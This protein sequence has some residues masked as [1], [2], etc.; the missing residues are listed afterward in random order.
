VAGFFIRTNDDIMIFHSAMKTA[1]VIALLVPALPG[2]GRQSD[3]EDAPENPAVTR[4][5][6]PRDPEGREDPSEKLREA[7]LAADAITEEGARRKALADIAWQAVGLDPEL[8]REA[9]QKLPTDADERIPLIRHFAMR[10]AGEDPEAALAWAGQLGSEHETAVARARIAL[11]IADSDPRRAA[12]LVAESGDS[13][14]ELDVAV[15]QVLQQW[16]ARSPQEAAE[17]AVLFPDDQI[18][19]AGIRTV[20]SRWL[21]TDP[22]AAVA[23]MAAMDHDGARAEVV[24]I[25]ARV[26][27]RQP[28]DIREVW[29]QS[30]DGETRRAI[31]REMGVPR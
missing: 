31:E 27:A 2:C 17:W 24:K 25:A 8:A 23:W 15:V 30:A 20:I 3:R 10:Q 29:L 12:V 19:E 13:G 14:R 4:S 11:V 28:G 9:F 22:Q 18:R 6:V 21:T 7:L 16:T 26:I 5:G 1:A